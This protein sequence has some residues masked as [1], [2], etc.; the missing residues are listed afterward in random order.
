MERGRAALHDASVTGDEAVFRSVPLKLDPQSPTPF[1]R[2]VYALLRDAIARGVL[3]PGERLPS[4][5][6]LASQLVTARGTIDLAYGLL[7]GE[8]YVLSRGAAGTF[9]SPALQAVQPSA[10]RQAAST[11]RPTQGPQ[12]EPPSP[13]PFQMGLPAFDAFPRKLWSRL[14]TRR[15]RALPIHA[16]LSPRAI[17]Y[18]PLR[19]AIA[20]Y[21]AMSRS[22]RCSAEQVIITSA[23]QG[24]LGLIARAF[25]DPGNEV[26][27]EDPGY[28]QARQALEATGAKL[29]SVPVDESGLDV[30]LGI[31]R[32][33]GARLAYV[34]PAHQAPLG[35]AL[36][37]SR[38][39]ALLNWAAAA[40]AWII[41][42]DYD[43]E[44]RYGSRPLPALKS[45]DESGR[46]LYV[47]TFSKVLFPGLRLGYLV[48]PDSQVDRVTRAARLLQPGPA[49]FNQ[50][51][52]TDFMTEGH[53]ARHIKRMRNLYAERRA[54]L[55]QALHE[56]FEARLSLQLQAGG[57][58]LV[59]R[60][61]EAG[62]DL[63]QVARANGRGLAPAPLSPWSIECKHQEQR[64]LLS[65][66]N[67]PVEEAKSAALRLKEALFVDD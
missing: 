60:F 19:E 53:L 43:G 44:F 36:S 2:Q 20:S 22:I 52:V 5:R 57:M 14:A 42:D 40:G 39:M 61:A 59:A 41:E 17:G 64:L 32:A 4:A 9:V 51:V 67:I 8:G 27:F 56:V 23:F 50:A 25:L 16:M 15:A 54:A 13:A 37:L 55:V 35:V 48:V 26:W 10:G 3:Q 21:L 47:G 49:A 28:F 33:P 34:T 24:A 7:A 46:V 31:A 65:F 66:T 58:H 63:E 12:A 6:S 45:L 18:Q 11:V 38:R 29:V 1:Y 30:A 62:S